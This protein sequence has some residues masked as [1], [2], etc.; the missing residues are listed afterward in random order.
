MK[1]LLTLQWTVHSL[2]F[3]IFSNIYILFAN[4]F[5]RGIEYFPMDQLYI[6]SEHQI[7]QEHN[8]RKQ[9]AK[10]FR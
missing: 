9:I 2:L 1:I 6:I 10:K 5:L 3:S 7:M 4:L 8:S